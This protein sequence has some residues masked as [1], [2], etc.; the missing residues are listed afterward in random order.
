MWSLHDFVWSSTVNYV[1]L[2]QSYSQRKTCSVTTVAA[3]WKCFQAWRRGTFS[4][5]VAVIRCLGAG[6]WYWDYITKVTEQCYCREQGSNVATLMLPVLQNNLHPKTKNRKG[7]VVFMQ[8]KKK[9]AA[10]LQ[11]LVKSFWGGNLHLTISSAFQTFSPPLSIKQHWSCK[12][13]NISCQA[14]HFQILQDFKPQLCVFLNKG[15]AFFV[16]KSTSWHSGLKSE[17][18]VSKAIASTQWTCFQQVFI[19]VNK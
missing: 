9:K 11:K 3:I 10:V 15:L 5:E 14:C 17:V 8:R 6:C 12:T 19:V 7:E 18:C 1:W 16:N 13:S 2:S 4:E